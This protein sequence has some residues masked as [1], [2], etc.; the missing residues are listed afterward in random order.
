ML[1]NQHRRHG[2]RHRKLWVFGGWARGAPTCG[3]LDLFAEIERGWVEPPTVDGVVTPG[4]RNKATFEKARRAA[5]G[6]RPHVH[7]LDIEELTSSPA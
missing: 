4:Y 7:V 1:S 3:D 6:A 2:A 5:L